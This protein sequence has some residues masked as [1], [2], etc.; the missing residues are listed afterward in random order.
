MQA[1]LKFIR[2]DYLRFGG[3]YI[4]ITVVVGLSQF[5][6]AVARVNASSLIDSPKFG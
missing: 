2:L 4:G 6:T 1:I 5:V 3:M